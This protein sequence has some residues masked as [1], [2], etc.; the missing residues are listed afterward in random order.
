MARIRG[1]AKQ[2]ISVNSTT[3]LRTVDINSTTLLLRRCRT[4]ITCSSSGSVGP[5]TRAN[6][7]I[8][9]TYKNFHSPTASGTIDFR[10]ML[11][12][13]PPIPTDD[14]PLLE[15]F[16][17]DLTSSASCLE[18]LRRQGTIDSDRVALLLPAHRLRKGLW[19][20]ST[21]LV[22]DIKAQ[23]IVVT[24]VLKSSPCQSR[25]PTSALFSRL[26]Q[27]LPFEFHHQSRP[28]ITHNTPSLVCGVQITVNKSQKSSTCTPTPLSLASRTRSAPTVKSI[29]PSP[30]LL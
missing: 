13:S 17:K 14:T 24:V 15:P 19:A 12:I 9:F 3:A 5:F 8:H 1:E 10:W 29:R 25:W 27:V 23:S 21:C 22:I 16:W 30:T 4:W 28:G 11:Q 7:P 26:V 6:V 20:S 18:K 2:N